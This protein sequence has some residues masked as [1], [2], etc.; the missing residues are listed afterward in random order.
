MNLSYRVFKL[1]GD[2]LKSVNAL[3]GNK[4]ISILKEEERTEVSYTHFQL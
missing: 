1:A 2:L 4:G 3:A